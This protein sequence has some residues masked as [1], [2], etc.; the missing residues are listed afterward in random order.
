MFFYGISTIWVGIAVGYTNLMLALQNENIFIDKL[1]GLYNR[2]YLDKIL[3][4]LQRKRK[5]AMMMLDMNGFKSINDNFGHSQ[6][7]EALVSLADI[8]E[9]TVGADGTVTRFAGDEF[10]ILLNTEK[11]NVVEK[12]KAQIKENLD[13]FNK[14]SQKNYKL[15]AS[16]GFGVF[17][18]SEGSADQILKI[19]DKRMYEDKKAYYALESHSRRDK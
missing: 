1:T 16:I 18:L 10:V 4:E 17:N 2:Y 6:G 5:I 12:C 11:E 13:E 14:G 15:S 8:L 7:D 9:K 19:I 3:G